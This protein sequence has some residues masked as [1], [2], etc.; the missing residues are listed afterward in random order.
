MHIYIYKCI[1]LSILSIPP[2]IAEVWGG[3]GGFFME[4]WLILAV[5]ALFCVFFTLLTAGL[6]LALAYWKLRA[7]PKTL[8]NVYSRIFSLENAP[9]PPCPLTP[10]VEAL[11]KWIKEAEEGA[12]LAEA[13]AKREIYSAAGKKSQEVQAERKAE[14]AAVLPQANQIILS[15]GTNDEKKNKLLSLLQ[16]HPQIAEIAARQLD[17]QFGLAEASGMKKAD[18]FA[19]V[20]DLAQK[21][22]AKYGQGQ[23]PASDP[24]SWYGLTPKD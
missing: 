21:A 9:A 6:A 15:Q 22:I 11:E 18:F 3:V 7:L 2:G 19:M 4:N 20:A 14:L 12:E 23:A 10:R 13:E 8:E 24:E 1:E 17:K 5:S 16:E